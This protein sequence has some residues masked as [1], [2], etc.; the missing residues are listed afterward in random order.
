M[1]YE[2]IE[3]K[4]V[5]LE[6]AL[7]ALHPQPRIDPRKSEQCLNVIDY[8]DY[9]ARS[10]DFAYALVKRNFRG[11]IFRGLPC[12]PVPLQLH[13]YLPTAIVITQLSIEKCPQ[14]GHAIYLR[15]F[16]LQIMS[17]Y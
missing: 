8:V 17:Y 3:S 4:G 6:E 5:I 10:L 12:W 14:I 7:E 2:L 16:N 13:E 1:P 11:L 9:P 15:F